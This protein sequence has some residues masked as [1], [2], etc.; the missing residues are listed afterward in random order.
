[1]ST[2]RTWATLPASLSPTPPDLGKRS[3]DRLAEQQ[4]ADAWK[5]KLRWEKKQSELKEAEK[6]ADALNIQSEASYPSLTS[7]ASAS[8]PPRTK[9]QSPY[10]NYADSVK[11]PVSA[12]LPKSE[13]E[14]HGDL[15]FPR[16]KGL[17]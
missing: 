14:F 7:S 16:D 17:W 11:K 3:K 8:M 13:D 9:G 15:A 2:N 4:E 10:F 6:L 1:M 12:P 5:S